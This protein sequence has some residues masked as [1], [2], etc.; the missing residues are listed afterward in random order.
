MVATPCFAQEAEIE[1]RYTI[2]G[3]LWDAHRNN[4]YYGFYEGKIY[5]V[6]YHE[7]SPNVQC[8]AF[9]KADYMISFFSFY[10]DFLSFS[11]AYIH[12]IYVT[13]QVWSDFM[14]LIPQESIG[15]EKLCLTPPNTPYR[16]IDSN[17]TMTSDNW[18]T[19]ECT[20][21]Y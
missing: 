17:L 11:I 19:A 12:S 4:Q 7:D 15:W 1:G 8:A 16:C 14:F 18:S 5:Q 13:F 20:E 10:F 2:E 6:F 3:T 9:A 21:L